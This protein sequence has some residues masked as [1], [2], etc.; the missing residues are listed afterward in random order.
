MDIRDLDKACAAA[1]GRP[2]SR[3]THGACCTCQT[4][5][6]DYDNCQ[7]GYADHDYPEKTRM[8]E[9]EIEKRGL[10]ESYIRELEKFV[11]SRDPW[12]FMR[13][14]PEAR[15]RAFLAAIEI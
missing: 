6:W 4:C 13:A 10:Q 14:A 1:L 8:L 12:E 9:D 5:G 15:A 11:L 2:W 3:P 7:C